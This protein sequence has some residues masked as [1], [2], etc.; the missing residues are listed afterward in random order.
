MLVAAVVA[1]GAP[2]SGEA[3]PSQN[4]EDY[5]ASWLGELSS[6]ARSLTMSL[7]SAAL[8]DADGSK[9]VAFVK[10]E[11]VE[12]AKSLIVVMRR[13][14]SASSMRAHAFEIETCCSVDMNL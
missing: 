8:D 5:T 12:L 10:A 7:T 11:F 4:G 3:S 2:S 13:H 6:P 14:F 1:D 9:F